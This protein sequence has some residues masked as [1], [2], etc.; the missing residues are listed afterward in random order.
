MR[1]KLLLLKLCKLRKKTSNIKN[2]DN[3]FFGNFI[4]AKKNHNY[5][6]EN[7]FSNNNLY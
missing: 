4:E 2:F 7:L 6:N 5:I 1:I 3:I